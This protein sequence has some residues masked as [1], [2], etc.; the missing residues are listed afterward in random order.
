[1][2]KSLAS[3]LICERVGEACLSTRQKRMKRLA[4]V[5]GALCMLVLAAPVMGVAAILIRVTSRGPVLY[6]QTRV[7]VSGREFELLKLRTMISGAEEE[8][9]PVMARLNDPRMTKLGRL[10]RAMHIDELPQLFNVL[11]GEMSLV[12]PRPERPHFVSIFQRKVAGY[13]QRLAVKP[14]ITGLAQVRG[15]YWT[16]PEQKLRYDLEYIR[17]YSVALDAAIFLLTIAVV[18]RPSRTERLQHRPAWLPAHGG[19]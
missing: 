1:M 11:A 6:R 16:R 8:T 15:S 14:G 4:D 10:L 19:D 18:L 13:E 3:A 17:H 5:A 9:G 7:G 12:G 2:A